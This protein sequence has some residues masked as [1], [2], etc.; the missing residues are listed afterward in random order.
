M[1][2]AYSNENKTNS[3]VPEFIKSKIQTIEL[4]PGLNCNI[5]HRVKLAFQL[6]SLNIYISGSS[7]EEVGTLDQIRRTEY[8]KTGGPNFKNQEGRK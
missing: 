4:Q 8:I 6:K 5:T 1:N 7:F 3:S 2:L